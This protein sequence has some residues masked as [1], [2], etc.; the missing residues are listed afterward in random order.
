MKLSTACFCVLFLP[1]CERSAP[2]LLLTNDT[3]GAGL[4][5][6]VHVVGTTPDLSRGRTGPP[7][8]DFGWLRTPACLAFPSSYL[9][10]GESWTPSLRISLFVD[11]SIGDSWQAGPFIPEQ[12]TAWNV[13]LT[14]PTPM[15]TTS[16]AV[17]SAPG[18]CGPASSALGGP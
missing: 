16:V 15:T 11:D 18:P 14:A 13:N 2:T 4:C 12:A 5:A 6:A 8:I 17:H 1:A 3:C 10:S 9:V 7:D